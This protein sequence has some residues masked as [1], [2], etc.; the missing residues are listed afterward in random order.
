MSSI[1]RFFSTTNADKA[2]KRVHLSNDVIDLS[3]DV[4]RTRRYDVNSDFDEETI[5]NLCQENGIIKSLWCYSK[6]KTIEKFRIIIDIWD[7]HSMEVLENKGYLEANEKA[8]EKG[9][10]RNPHTC[11]YLYLYYFLFRWCGITIKDSVQ[12]FKN[13]IIK[14]WPYP[15]SSNPDDQLFFVLCYKYYNNIENKSI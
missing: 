7:V 8:R 3:N 12:Q 15:P 1:N 10:R 2:S 4:P 5:A 13:H 6:V 11:L 9:S 14:C